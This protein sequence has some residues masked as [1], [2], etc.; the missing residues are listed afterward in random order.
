M[1]RQRRSWLRIPIMKIFRK[2]IRDRISDIIAAD[3]GK[4]VTRVLDEA[5]Y[6]SALENKLLEEVQEMRQAP[7]PGAAGQGA[8]KAEEIADIYEVL[9]AIIVAHGFSASDIQ[10]L[11]AKKRAERGGFEKRLFLESVE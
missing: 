5:E 7:L 1:I 10:V 4:A 8:H 2:L 11:K 3:G 6:R 9:D